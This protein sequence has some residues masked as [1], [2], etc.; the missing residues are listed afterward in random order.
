MI[1]QSNELQE[2]RSQYEAMKKSQKTLTEMNKQMIERHSLEVDQ[3]NSQLREANIE[4]SSKRRKMEKY[5]EIIT[6]FTQ[7]ME[8]FESFQKSTSLEITMLKNRI[9]EKEKEN[10][11]L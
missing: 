10:D 2:M 8:I 1:T 7:Q 11:L 3:L 5:V 9:R 6:S 4:L